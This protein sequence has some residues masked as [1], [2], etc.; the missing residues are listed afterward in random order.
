[1]ATRTITRYRSARPKARRRSRAQFTLPLAVL[2][3]F[4]PTAA[5][6]V[7]TY[8]EQGIEGGVKAAAMRLT[9]YN[10]WVGN[11]YAQE[12]LKGWLPIL[13]GVMAHK[14]AGRLGINRALSRAGIPFVR[15]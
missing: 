12:L 13:A 6:A 9:G 8:R 15:V 1:M 10:S 11:W 4:V 7:Q 14:L 2:G 5:F 3:G